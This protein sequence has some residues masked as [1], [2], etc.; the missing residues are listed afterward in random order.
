MQSNPR[1]DK[2]LGA[3]LTTQLTQN[4]L[5]TVR[6]SHKRRS[7]HPTNVCHLQQSPNLADLRA[8]DIRFVVR[9]LPQPA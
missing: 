1:I 4:H 7:R 8:L 5:K 3:G 2:E 9:E 6:F